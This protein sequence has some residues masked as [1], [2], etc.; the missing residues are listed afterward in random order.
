VEEAYEGQI[1]AGGDSRLGWED[2]EAKAGE[3]RLGAEEAP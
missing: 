3:R 2:L 1:M